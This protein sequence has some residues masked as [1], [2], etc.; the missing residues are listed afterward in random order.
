MLKLSFE[1][2]ARINWVLLADS[3]LSTR[4]TCDIQ[5]KSLQTL[6]SDLSV[7]S[8]LY[9]QQS[10]LKLLTISKHRQLLFR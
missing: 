7:A 8:L 6:T 4:C 1:R 9:R 10:T 3:A 5:F 2:W